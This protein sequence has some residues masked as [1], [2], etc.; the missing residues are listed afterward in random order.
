[1][2]MTFTHFYDQLYSDRP[3]AEAWAVAWADARRT[4]DCRRI[5]ERYAAGDAAAETEIRAILASDSHLH[6][7]P[8]CEEIALNHFGMVHQ[9]ALGSLAVARLDAPPSGDGS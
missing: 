2:L 1:M 3:L 9:P 7:G 5:I 4:L 6:Y 8:M